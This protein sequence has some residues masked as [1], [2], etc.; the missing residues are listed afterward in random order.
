MA[1][2]S[3]RMSRR[4]ALKAGAA[5]VGGGAATLLGAGALAAHPSTDARGALSEVEGQGGA[6]AIATNAQG[7]RRFKAFVKAGPDRP[8]VVELAARPLTGNQVLLRVQAAQTCY[9]SI[10]QVLKNDDR[11]PDAAATIVGHGGVGIVEAVG[12][13][14]NSVRVGDRVVLNLHAACGRC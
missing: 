4:K 9:S 7:G 2:K 3:P 13:A 8:T 14:V 6:P 1:T 10:D 5:A 12:P 11:V